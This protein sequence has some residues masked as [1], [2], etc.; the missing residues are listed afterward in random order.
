MK[1]LKQ[2][3]LVL[4]ILLT[5]AAAVV[6]GFVI[7]LQRYARRR[8][9]VAA[10]EQTVS[11][12]AGDSF[13]TATARLAGAGVIAHPG[14]FKMLARYRGDDKR[15]K[16]GEY[17]FSGKLSP[18]QVLD[19]LVKGEVKLYKI[20]VPEGFNLDQIALLV[21]EAGLAA[22]DD[23]R[24]QARNPDLARALDIPAGT[25]EGYLFPDTYFF[26]KGATSRQVITTM[27]RRFHELFSDAWRKRAEQIGYSVH[28]V[29]T[30]ASI[31]EK[32]TGAPQERKL[33]ASVFHNRLRKGMRLE[34]DPTVIY[35]LDHFDGNLTRKH[36]ETPTPYN[37]YIIQGLPPGP[38]A[39]PGMAA[40]EAALFPADSDYLFF[41]S[42]GDGTH[43]FS[44]SLRDH[45][46]AVEKFQL[47]GRAKGN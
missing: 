34:A 2:F 38:I 15:L 16:A 41:V 40:L 33:I 43:Y 29:V 44:S 14:K 37:T 35:G 1:R 25:A 36:L 5:V 10:S 31:I 32:E 3:C 19:K 7:D 46:A 23:F 30:L 4:T 28:E 45:R 24:D 22:S 42:R 47:R 21:R 17:V 12:A 13:K 27:V 8:I 9:D 6:T 18:E 39:N 11:I 20:T 26:P